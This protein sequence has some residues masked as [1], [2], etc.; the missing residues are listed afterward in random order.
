LIPVEGFVNEA[1]TDPR[2]N[3]LNVTAC[4][5]IISVEIVGTE[6]SDPDRKGRAA[7]PLGVLGLPPEQPSH[8]GAE[9]LARKAAVAIDR[10]R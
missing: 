5:R 3:S 9:E 10:G 6:P 1:S 7:E 4:G 2:Y 8:D